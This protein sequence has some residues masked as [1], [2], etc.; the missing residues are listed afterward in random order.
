LFPPNFKI[1]K[2]FLG[3]IA[4]FKAV[5][6]GYICCEMIEMQLLETIIT[7]RI[8]ELANSIDPKNGENMDIARNRQESLSTNV[9]PT[10]ENPKEDQNDILLKA[11]FKRANLS[12]DPHKTYVISEVLDTLN[13]RFVS[14]KKATYMSIINLPKNEFIDTKTGIK[15]DIMTAIRTNKIKLEDT[16]ASSEKD[17]NVQP[18]PPT[19]LKLD[20]NNSNDFDVG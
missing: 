14:L 9:A 12:Y 6:K 11:I 15:L 10:I 2:T 7:A 16:S 5:E 4:L 3:P 20:L 18:P 19:S 1:F 17:N 8:F 13:D